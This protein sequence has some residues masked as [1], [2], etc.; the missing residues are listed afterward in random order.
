ML[1]GLR[2][3]LC[4]GSDPRNTLTSE[5]REPFPECC[6]EKHRPKI[7]PGETEL[8][9]RPARP[10]AK[11]R[12]YCPFS[13]ESRFQERGSGHYA[14]LIDLPSLQG[15]ALSGRLEVDWHRVWRERRRREQRSD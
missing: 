10:P 15:L 6:P 1:H 11:L 3:T 12:P 2:W 13:A 9:R 14:G 7:Y 4:D 5:G 8:H